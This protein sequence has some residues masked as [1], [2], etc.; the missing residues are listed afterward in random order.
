MLTEKIQKV[1]AR[2][3][4]ASRREVERWISAGRITVDGKPAQAGDRISPENKV[5][6]DGK[7]IFLLWEQQ[8]FRVLAYHKPEGEICSR[9]DPE[10]SK[11]IYDRLPRLTYGRW[12]SAGRL[13]INTTG[14][15]LLSNDGELIN[16][17][18]HPSHQIER[19]YAVRVLGEVTEEMLARLSQGVLLEDGVAK[20]NHIQFA[21]GEGANRWY[22]VVLTEGRNRE[23]RRLWESQGVKVSRLSRI[24]F[25][26]IK[27]KREQRQGRYEELSS[28]DKKGLYESV[29]LQAPHENLTTHQPGKRSKKSPVWDKKPAAAP[30]GSK[31]YKRK[32]LLTPK[33]MRPA[34]K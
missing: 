23:V 14:L 20:F 17:L 11:T 31:L 18:M 21:G 5:S 27:L 22:H 7:P 1:V 32:K 9:N 15:I 29:G 26:N 6:L 30:A 28:A 3:G 8:Q 24:R 12:M 16:R 10:H 13:D 34:S 2:T 19:E 25:G 33:R 4:F